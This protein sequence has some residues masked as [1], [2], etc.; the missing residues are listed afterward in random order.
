MGS[1]VA[2]VV[3]SNVVEGGC[4]VGHVPRCGVERA[5]A[6]EVVHRVPVA[7]VGG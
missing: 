1:M 5:V 3:A 6:P 7:W 4:Q 2:C